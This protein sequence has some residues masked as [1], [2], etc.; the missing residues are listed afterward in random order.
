MKNIIKELSLSS[1]SV[2]NIRNKY[3]LS[4][5]RFNELLDGTI[6]YESDTQSIFVKLNNSLDLITTYYP[7]EEPRV[8]IEIKAKK[9]S[10]CGASLKPPFRHCEYCDTWFVF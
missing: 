7:K 10:C 3:Q 9:C 8:K 2:I 6:I 4:Q 1:V 5:E